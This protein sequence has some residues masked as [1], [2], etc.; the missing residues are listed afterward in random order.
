METNNNGNKGVFPGT[1]VP[2]TGTIQTGTPVAGAPKTTA[3]PTNISHH[4]TAPS[5]ANTES[6]QDGEATTYIRLET[7]NVEGQVSGIIEVDLISFRERGQES[8][9]LSV[10]TTGAD[11]EGNSSTTTINIDNEADFNRFKKFISQLNWN[12]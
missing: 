1:P 3:L 5:E 6:V 7:K 8:R 2:S 9:F 12:D 11:A 10:N 4:E